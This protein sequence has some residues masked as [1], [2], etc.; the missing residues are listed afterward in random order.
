MGG[1]ERKKILVTNDDSVNSPGLLSL[2]KT[3]KGVGEVWVVAPD[4]EQSTV[5]H[6]LTLH[7]PLR[8]E[9]IS[10]RFFT[11]NG[12]PTDCVNLACNGIL[13]EK[14]SLV[15]SGINKGPNLGDDITYSGTVSAAIEGTLLGIPSF[16]ISLVSNPPFK[17]QPAAN[18]ARRLAHF[19]LKNGL[20]PD[21]LLNVNVPDT[22]GKEVN[23]YRITR[24]GKR[25]YGEPIV[26]RV[27]PRGRKYYWVGGESL[28]FEEISNSD[29]EAISKNCISITPIHLDLTNYSSFEE[30]LKWK[31]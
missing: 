7:R 30:L 19:I 31:L 28:G 23:S 21:T 11:V 25:I 3:L 17:F 12:T 29:F 13:K 14:P 24:Q 4:R 26:E 18:F 8:V 22:D 6:S 20:L 1:K 15:V 9:E 5:S 10:P 27:D 16:A 2:A